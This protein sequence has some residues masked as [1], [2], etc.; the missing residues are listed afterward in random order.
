MWFT[1]IVLHPEIHHVPCNQYQGQVLQGHQGKGAYD[2]FNSIPAI[3]VPA[4]NSH[5]P[6][7]DSSCQPANTANQTQHLPVRNKPDLTVTATYLAVVMQPQEF[8]ERDLCL[9]VGTMGHG[10]HAFGMA[11]MEDPEV[12]IASISPTGPP[13][14]AYLR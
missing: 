2:E 10:E 7:R 1:G 11:F 9:A 4:Q 6:Y 3:R 13:Y 12:R 14:Q 5:Q 8:F